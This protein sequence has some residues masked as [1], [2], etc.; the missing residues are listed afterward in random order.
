MANQLD[1]CMVNESLFTRRYIAVRKALFLVCGLSLAGCACDCRYVEPPIP[2]GGAPL[3]RPITTESS[4]G[5][6]PLRD[7][8]Y[9]G[10]Y[11]SNNTI[12]IAGGALQE[13]TPVG[14]LSQS[15]GSADIWSK[16][17]FP[18]FIQLSAVH[19]R[20][21]AT[22]LIAGR[23]GDPIASQSPQG[24]WSLDESRS[25]VSAQI[26]RFV[27]GQAGPVGIGFA[28]FNS[29]VSPRTLALVERSRGVWESKQAGE[30]TWSSG[31][32]CA[33]ATDSGQIFFVS[34]ER[35]P[36]APEQTLHLYSSNDG[37][38]WTSRVEYHWPSNA[39]VPKPS[40][41]VALMPLQIAM[42]VEVQGEAQIWQTDGTAPWTVIGQAG[43]GV[44]LRIALTAGG[45]GVLIGQSGFARW[46]TDGGRT[47]QAGVGL[48]PV[49]S[50]M[51]VGSV[52]G[53]RYFALGRSSGFL[54]SDG[55]RTWM[56]RL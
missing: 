37:R 15:D 3:S 16:I 14:L 35:R 45:R 33:A 24:Q 50:F 27:T 5:G 29:S 48:D 39:P 23:I 1:M 36:L 19:R 13:Q 53:D 20:S 32:L 51:Q 9:Y 11:F 22:Y 40:D 26:R 34:E 56:R 18:S 2:S 49:E 38:V 55:G 42:A 6:Q 31:P 17:V 21:D 8:V 4:S 46:T 30:G 41:C 54:T 25:H 7:V 52:G 10:A 28:P 44:G 43:Y 47:W 12:A